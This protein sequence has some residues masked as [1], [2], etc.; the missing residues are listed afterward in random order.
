MKITAAGNLCLQFLGVTMV[1]AWTLSRDEFT[2]DKCL[3]Q[4]DAL[5]QAKACNW[6]QRPRNAVKR[7]S[8]LR[9]PSSHCCPG[10]W[11]HLETELWGSGASV[12]QSWPYPS[13]CPLWRPLN[14]AWRSLLLTTDRQLE[15][16]VHSWLICQPETFILWALRILCE[17]GSIELK[18]KEAL[19]KNYVLVRSL[20]LLW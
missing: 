18:I 20:Q 15:E 7:P 10:C 16:T 3:I 12:I 17:D 5:R 19:V 8:V 4:S 6:M 13:D 9:C 11:N 1:A 14:E 2:S